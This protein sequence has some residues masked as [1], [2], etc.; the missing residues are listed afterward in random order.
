MQLADLFIFKREQY[1]PPSEKAVQVFWNNIIGL[2]PFSLEKFT[3]ENV[4]T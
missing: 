4:F 1:F 2:F 3:T